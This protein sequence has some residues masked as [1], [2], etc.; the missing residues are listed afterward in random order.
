VHQLQLQLQEMC[1]NKTVK[2]PAMSVRRANY[3]LSMAGK[4][5]DV[6]NNMTDIV[7]LIATYQSY[8]TKRA[9]PSS[10]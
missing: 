9:R 10:V 2:D 3:Q 8:E 4:I 1:C 5:T 7:V 6:E